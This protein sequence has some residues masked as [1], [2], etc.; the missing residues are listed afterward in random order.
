ME[1]SFPIRSTVAKSPDR[2]RF[3]RSAA[4]KPFYADHD[5]AGDWLWAKAE[6]ALAY[7]L[8]PPELAKEIALRRQPEVSS[9]DPS[10]LGLY[11]LASSHGSSPRL[12]EVARISILRAANAAAI[13]AEGRQSH[14]VLGPREYSWGSA[15]RV[16][17]W[18]AFFLIAYSLQPS[19]LL[20]QAALDQL[21][22][23]LGNNAADHSFITGFGAH[24]VRHPYHW[25]YED[26]GVAVAG[27]AVLGP[28]GYPDG[29][30]PGASCLTGTGNRPSP[31]LCGH[32]QQGRFM[33]L[34]RTADYRGSCPCFPDGHAASIA[35]RGLEVTLS[36][37]V[38][39][40]SAQTNV[41]GNGVCG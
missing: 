4:V 33:G 30:D 9:D 27:W 24:P 11:Q 20:H 35:T 23:M 19:S 26:Y 41:F 13:A 18:A 28:N 17:H 32:V 7:S 22:W 21:A 34:K 40:T 36:D 37:V 14:V 10:L 2:T 15:E 29:V 31:L 25:A 8:D 38:H 12:R 5:L 39:S 6:H 3:S 16:L 1:L